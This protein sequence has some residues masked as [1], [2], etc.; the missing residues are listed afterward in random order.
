[1]QSENNRTTALKKEQEQ[2]REV[3]R[4]EEE[5]RCESNVDTP[6]FVSSKDRN[7]AKY[8]RFIKLYKE[9]GHRYEEHKKKIDEIAKAKEPS[10]NENGTQKN[11]VAQE[12]EMDN[13]PQQQDDPKADDTLAEMIQDI[14]QEEKP[15]E[16]EP[17]TRETTTPMHSSK[18]Q[19]HF[20][21]FIF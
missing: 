4:Q 21:I 10:L 16:L 18:F 13:G 9:F 8:E 5:S 15:I 14:C 2:L 6:N 1:M 7:I 12:E 19:F 17:E 11:E 3:Q 20:H